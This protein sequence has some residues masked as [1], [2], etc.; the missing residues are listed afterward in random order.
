MSEPKPLFVYGIV[1][2]K[3]DHM[4][5]ADAFWNETIAWAS[6]VLIDHRDSSPGFNMVYVE[7]SGWLPDERGYLKAYQSYKYHGKFQTSMGTFR[8]V[9]ECVSRNIRSET[10]GNE[11]ASYMDFQI[12][13]Y[14]PNPGKVYESNP[15]AEEEIKR[16]EFYEELAS[17]WDEINAKQ[18]AKLDAEDDTRRTERLIA[19][20]SARPALPEE[21]DELREKRAVEYAGAFPSLSP[22]YFA[23]PTVMESM[24]EKYLDSEW[25]TKGLGVAHYGYT[26]YDEF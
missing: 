12:E 9:P 8:A 6:Y 22:P 18:K 20:S 15:Q 2:S 19:S 17:A 13:Y 4:A 25:S 16:R 26:V 7:I 23:L 10:E 5:I 14:I 24:A 3:Y 11:R 21:T 1:P